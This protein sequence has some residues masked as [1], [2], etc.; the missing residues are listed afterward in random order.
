VG[1]FSAHFFYF[2]TFAET[3][4]ELITHGIE[5]KVRTLADQVVGRDGYDLVDV[6]YKRD[7]AGW[8]L[9]L[10]IDKQ[11]GVNLDDCQRVSHVMSTVLDVEVPDLHGYN[12]QVSSPGLDR[13][14]RKPADYRGA[15]GRRV[16]IITKE[17]IGN[18]RNFT[19][20]LQ[21]LAP[22]DGEPAGGHEELEIGEERLIVHLQ[23]DSGADHAIPFGS[24]KRSNLVYQWPDKGTPV[25]DKAARGS[26]RQ[27]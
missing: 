11:G 23:D 6:E 20:V 18:R 4:M 27:R 13:P 10:F 26:G 12:L 2:Y 21:S 17:P 24:I 7:V 5:A 1:E 15:R 22:A 14:L 16:R 3:A 25:R 19:G 9:T 8:T